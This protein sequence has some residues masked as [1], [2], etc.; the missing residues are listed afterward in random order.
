MEEITVRLRSAPRAVMPVG[1]VDFTKSVAPA[2]VASAP[3]GD[4]IRKE[5]QHL[6]AICARLQA[7]LTQFPERQAKELDDW[8]HA[9]VELALAVAARVLRRAIDA[10]EFP[11]EQMVQEMIAP[12]AASGEVCVYLNPQ[13]L[14]AFGDCPAGLRLAADPALGRGDCRVEDGNRLLIARLP[15]YLREVREAMIRSLNAAA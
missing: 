2:P 14:R 9:A 3:E 5:R 1:S 15:E 11:I 10:G 8:R 6:E 13:D 4:G 7:L 12:L